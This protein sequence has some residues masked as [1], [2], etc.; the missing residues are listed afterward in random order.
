M[1]V[2]ARLAVF[3]SRTAR[4]LRPEMAGA[5]RLFVSDI[6]ALAPER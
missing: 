5:T 3:S 6:G 1:V 4:A 2:F